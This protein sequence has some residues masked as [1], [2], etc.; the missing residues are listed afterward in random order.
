MGGNLPGDDSP[1][2]IWLDFL[3]FLKDRNTK[4]S[5]RQQ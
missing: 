5:L 4:H 1:G 2:G 3:A